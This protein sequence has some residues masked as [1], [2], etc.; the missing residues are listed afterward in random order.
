M[1]F[2]VHNLYI[3]NQNKEIYKHLFQSYDQDLKYFSTFNYDLIQHTNLDNFFF[4][5]KNNYKVQYLQ[6]KNLLKIFGKDLKQKYENGLMD[7]T[8]SNIYQLTQGDNWINPFEFNKLVLQIQILIQP[9]DLINLKQQSGLGLYLIYQNHDL[10]DIMYA[11]K[12]RDVYGVNLPSQAWEFI[13]KN[14]WCY[15]GMPLGGCYLPRNAVINISGDQNREHI[16]NNKHGFYVFI[17]KQ[18]LEVPS[19]AQRYLINGQTYQGSLLDM[20]P[21][22]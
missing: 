2:K 8:H 17:P 15:H 4:E 11:K 21:T 18:Y 10:G 12:T 3:W 6:I 9:G 7:D 5:I 19:Q 20:G 13:E 22:T 1:K 14:G 16:L